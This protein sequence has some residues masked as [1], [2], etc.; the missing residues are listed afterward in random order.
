MKSQHVWAWGWLSWTSRALPQS[1][2]ALSNL[3]IKQMCCS[4][5][6]LLILTRDGKL[7]FMYFCSDTPCP[8]LIEILKDKEVVKIASHTEGKHHL[9]LT[10]DYKVYSWGNGDGGRLG[11][12]DNLSKDEPTLIEAL[13]DKE[14]IDVVCG[15]TYSAAISSNGALYT[16]GRGNFGRLGHGNSEDCSLPTM[17]EALSEQHIVRVACGSGDAHTLCVTNNGKVYSWGDGDY[18]KLGRGGSD[19]SKVPRLVDKLQD[20]VIVEVYCGAQCSFAVS[21]EGKVFSWGKG[22]EWRLGHAYEE[23]V[24]FPKVIE[25]LEGLRFG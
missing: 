19:G 2:D 4:D 5:R 8:Q 23:H 15:G 14:I 11:H 7:Y 22:D 18:G 1:F 10:A 6:S 25:A 21:K 13:K 24:R 3:N 20:I 9:A 12:G 16:W 17:V